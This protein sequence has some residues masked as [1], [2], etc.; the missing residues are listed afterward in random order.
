MS[1]TP[2]SSPKQ[3]LKKPS[4][5]FLYTELGGYT[6]ACIKKLANT[7]ID[8]HVVHFPVNKEAPFKLEATEGLHFYQNTEFSKEGLLQ[9]VRSKAPA[10]IICSG[11]VDK[12]YIYVCRQMRGYC[13]LTLAIDNQ[14][15]STWKQR[16]GSLVA[17][18]SFIRYFDHIWVPG[19]RQVRYARKMGVNESKIHTGF[20]CCDVKLY[21]D[22]YQSAYISKKE[23]L[24]KRFLYVGRY[25]DYK[26]IGDLWEA[27]TILQQELPNEWELWCV[28][29]GDLVP[30]PHPSIRHFG[31]VQPDEMLAVV[32]DSGVF[33]MPSR[34]D[35]WGVA[36]QE[37]CIAGY[38]LICSDRVGASDTFLEEGIN[39]FGF[40]GE[41][42]PGLKEAMKRMVLSGEKELQ[43]MGAKSHLKGI[44]ITPESWIQTV[45]ELMKNE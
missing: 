4:V 37:F 17:R 36:L 11:W 44:S 45:Y 34:F 30:L 22:Y 33:V 41:D 13:K 15:R 7:G 39:G 26:G 42:I 21:E 2:S 1:P 14:W 29:M 32:K 3:L 43:Q 31:F 23:K 28:G 18:W 9:L 5:F 38:P 6:L 40:P 24:P 16:L 8:V 35:Q 12:N 27:F 10:L 25:F 19:K 20:Y